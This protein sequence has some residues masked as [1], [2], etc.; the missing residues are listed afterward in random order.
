M[1]KVFFLL[2]LLVLVGTTSCVNNS[3]YK[4]IR[5]LNTSGDSYAYFDRDYT[6]CWQA[7]H[8]FLK[9]KNAKIIYS[10]SREG[11]IKAH[12]PKENCTA[13]FYFTPTTVRSTHLELR[14]WAKG[15]N[16]RNEAMRKVI[17]A[18]VSKQLQ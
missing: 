13:W 17:F 18:E 10:S 6:G 15:K 8:K 16:V 4:A 12:L 3:K 5:S 1:K 9:A 14:V 11:I 2:S 7:S